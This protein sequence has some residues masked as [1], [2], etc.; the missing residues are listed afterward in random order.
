[1]NTIPEPQFL[2]NQA[3]AARFLGLS[4]RTIELWRR[5][6]K[7]PRFV[8]LSRRAVRYDRADLLQFVE[9]R[10]CHSTLEAER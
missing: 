7:G 3:Q 2:L 4:Q 5:Q 1:M 9:S 10:K 6:G 8:S